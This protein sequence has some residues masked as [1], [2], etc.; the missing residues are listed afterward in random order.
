[1]TKTQA[2]ARKAAVIE[3]ADSVTSTAVP[4]DAVLA[5]TLT[6][7]ESTGASTIYYCKKFKKSGDTVMINFNGEL[8][9]WYGVDV[10]GAE[11]SMFHGNSTGKAR[12]SKA[13]CTLVVTKGLVNVYTKR[14]ALSVN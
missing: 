11:F 2:R 4:A 7:T 6:V 1:M 3:T 14:A 9:N 8:S 13:W 5:K 10:R 12:A